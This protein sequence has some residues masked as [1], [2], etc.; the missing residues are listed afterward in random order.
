[1]ALSDNVSDQLC[2]QVLPSSYGHHLTST[3][4]HQ[5]N[6][7]TVHGHMRDGDLD[8]WG[9][10]HMAPLVVHIHSVEA[11][12]VAWSIKCACGSDLVCGFHLRRE[13]SPEQ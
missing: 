6:G 12:G 2:Y 1:M 9:A 8:S 10:M 5:W 3:S 11:A 7:R 13:V 4:Y